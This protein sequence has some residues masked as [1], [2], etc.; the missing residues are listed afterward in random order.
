MTDIDRYVAAIKDHLPRKLANDLAADIR[1][2]LLE[3]LDAREQ[4]AGRALSVDERVEFLRQHG[5]PMRVGAGYH[6]RRALIDE[7]AFPLYKVTL[8][9]VLIG[10]VIAQLTQSFASVSAQQWNAV[11]MITQFYWGF[12]HAALLG[13][14][15]TTLVFWL[16]QDKLLQLAGLDQWNPKD[17]APVSDKAGRIGRGGT[18]FEFVFSLIALRWLNLDWIAPQALADFGIAGWNPD[19]MLWLRIVS[20]SIVASMLLNLANL[21]QPWHTQRKR[22][23]S[24]AVS[25]VS[26]LAL[27]GLY[28][29]GP[30]MVVVS[31]DHSWGDHIAAWMVH[32]CGW[33]SLIA[34]VD[35]GYQAWRGWQMGH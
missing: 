27:A 32:A 31:A 35:A 10:L 17:L 4:A 3:D 6:A 22:Y 13:F 19:A 29:L 15:V 34:L 26:A 1:S 28:G 18:A 14:A 23:I 7:S 12:A 25:L 5:H 21:F 30:D 9:Y 8:K 33:I 2:T 20:V 11:R 24:A 16:F